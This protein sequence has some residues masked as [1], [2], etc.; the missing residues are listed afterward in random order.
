MLNENVVSKANLKT[1]EVNIDTKLSTS[2]SVSI[3]ISNCF[4]IDCVQHCHS[5]VKNIDDIITSLNIEAT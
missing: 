3:H 1:L 2:I 4:G 5:N